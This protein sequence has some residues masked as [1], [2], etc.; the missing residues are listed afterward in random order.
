MNS[1][2]IK[3]ALMPV[4]MAIVTQASRKWGNTIGGLISSMP[5]I[6]GPILLFFILEQGKKFGIQSVPG[7]LT[8]IVSL[9]CFCYSYARLSSR[10]S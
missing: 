5:W 9:I 8:G 3:V 10:F 2:L 1:L 6:A 7:I 4:V